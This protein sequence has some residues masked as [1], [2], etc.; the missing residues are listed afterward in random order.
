MSAKVLQVAALVLGGTSSLAF[1]YALNDLAGGLRE[2]PQHW[3]STAPL[4]GIAIAVALY[5]IVSVRSH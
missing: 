4:L 2:A 1:G 3:W 5:V